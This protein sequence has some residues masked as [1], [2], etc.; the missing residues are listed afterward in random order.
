MR[1]EVGPCLG[2]SNNNDDMMLGNHRLR[3]LILDLR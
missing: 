3:N 2:D 1:I